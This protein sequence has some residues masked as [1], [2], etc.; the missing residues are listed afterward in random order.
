M[1]FITKLQKLPSLLRGSPARGCLRVNRV[2]MEV[3]HLRRFIGGKIAEV[4][5]YLDHSLLQY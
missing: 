2:E 3:M 4:W 1:L 5:E